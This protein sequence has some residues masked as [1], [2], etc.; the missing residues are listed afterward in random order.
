MEVAIPLLTLGG[1]FIISNK[2]KTSSQEGFNNKD[3]TKLNTK[4]RSSIN[5]HG[6]P[7]SGLL[8]GQDHRDRL[9]NT[10]IPEK[11]FTN[12]NQDY[13]NEKSIR[14]AYTENRDKYAVAGRKDISKGEFMSLTGEKVGMNNFEHNNLQPFFG[15]TVKQRTVNLD[16]NETLLDSKQGA[17]SQLFSKKESAPLF[18]PEDNVH[19]THGMPNHSTFIQSRMN[20]S[21]HMNNTKPWEEIHVAPGLD[22]G[23][24]NEGSGGFNSG[25]GARKEWEPKKVNEL[26]TENNPKNTYGGVILGGKYFNNERGVMGK[27]EKNRPDTAFEHNA[28]RYFTTTGAQIK[29]TARGEQVLGFSNRV[30]TTREYFGS[31]GDDNKAIYVKGQHQDPK[32]TPLDADVCHISNAYAGDRYDSSDGDYGIQGYNI[33]PNERTLTGERTKLGIVSTIAKEIILPIQDLLRPSRKENVVG[34]LR[35]TGN[36]GTAVSELQTSI[37]D[38]QKVTKKEM[39]VDNDFLFNIGNQEFGGYGHTTNEHQATFTHRTSTGDTD[40]SGIAGPAMYDAVQDYTSAY[41]AKLNENKEVVSRSRI[42]V[43]NTNM[44]NNYENISIAK[45]DKRCNNH[46]T[47]PHSMNASSPSL[48]TYGTLTN[49]LSDQNNINSQRMTSD[50]VEQF[51]NNPYTHKIGSLA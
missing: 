24:T 4:E 30:G 50:M 32:R 22:A 28:D 16:G 48:Q 33:L 2:D 35:P 12:T 19:W 21:R 49:N 8:I 14:D 27:M 7:G 5:K 31:G 36:A 34:N 18:K 6:G 43:G 23:F 46:I 15:S 9:S 3:I 39:M 26:R 37:T 51:N 41:N 38:K 20:P 17:G 11:N 40:Y 10:H 42:N 29:Q 45:D 1:L 13:T 47:H 44:F 25:L